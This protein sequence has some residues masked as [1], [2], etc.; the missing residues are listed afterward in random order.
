MKSHM[1]SALAPL[2]GETLLPSANSADDARVDIAARGFWQKCEKASFDCRIFNPYASTY[3]NQSISNVFKANEKEKRRYNQ[4]IVQIEHGSF[5]PL[6]FSAFGGCS[7]DTQHFLTT[8]ADQIAVNKHIQPS[9]VMS[10]LRKK[11]AF[12]LL[13]AQFLCR[14]GWSAISQR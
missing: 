2:S 7:R 1:T 8:L 4:R 12:A 9:I 13:R 10:W 11:I 5:T 3:R 6:V 14:H